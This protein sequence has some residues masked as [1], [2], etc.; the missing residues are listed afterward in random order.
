MNLNKKNLYFILLIILPL[1]V[2]T[3]SATFSFIDTSNYFFKTLLSGNFFYM[4]SADW[5]YYNPIIHEN[6]FQPFVGIFQNII[7]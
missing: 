4:Y 6:R 3:F 5:P 2:I 7:L 1:L